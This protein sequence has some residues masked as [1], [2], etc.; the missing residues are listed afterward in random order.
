MKADDIRRGGPASTP[1]KAEKEKI[2]LPAKIIVPATKAHLVKNLPPAAPRIVAKRPWPG[3]WVF[4]STWA[5]HHGWSK[6][7]S[8]SDA[9]NEWA[10]TATPEEIA[11]QTKRGKS[12]GWLVGYAGGYAAVNT[13]WKIIFGSIE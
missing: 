11:H 7:S 1:P 8:G 2:V 13:L 6:D 5:Y 12:Y 4:A 3:D 9:I 10:K